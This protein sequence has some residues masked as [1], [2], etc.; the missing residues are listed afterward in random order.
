MMPMSSFMFRFRGSD[1]KMILKI[2][3]LYFHLQRI[4]IL[5]TNTLHCNPITL[6]VMLYLN[7]QLC[8]LF[9][10]LNICV[11]AIMTFNTFLQFPHQIK[12][13]TS[14]RLPSELKYKTRF[15]V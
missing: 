7:L 6:L 12:S 9:L 2:Y 4:Y 1:L 13:L 5:T 11:E 15:I 8:Q 3:V 14:K 10:E